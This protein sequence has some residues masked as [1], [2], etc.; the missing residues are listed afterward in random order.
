M[1]N[2]CDNTHMRV[3]SEE[4]T[5]Q[6]TTVWTVDEDNSDNSSQHVEDVRDDGENWTERV[7]VET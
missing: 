2:K 6:H 1:I 5:G 7:W 3:V 4:S